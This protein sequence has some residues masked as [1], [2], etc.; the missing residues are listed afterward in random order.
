M[1]KKTKDSCENCRF[2]NSVMSD[3]GECRRRPPVIV[4]AGVSK[5][6]QDEDWTEVIES[7]WNYTEWPETFENNWCG[8]HERKL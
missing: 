3:V 5:A 1:K 2:W 4:D 6:L 7:I 8:E